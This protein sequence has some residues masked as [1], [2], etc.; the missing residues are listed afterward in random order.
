MNAGLSDKSHQDPAVEFLSKESNVSINDVAR[1]IRGQFGS[2][3]S[4]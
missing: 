2:Y 3:V 4:G 1:L